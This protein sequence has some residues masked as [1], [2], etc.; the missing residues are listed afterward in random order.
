MIHEWKFLTFL[1]VS[2]LLIID[3]CLLTVAWKKE[4]RS[5]Y[6]NLSSWPMWNA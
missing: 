3:F 5:F 4:Q 2:Y 6:W 1:P